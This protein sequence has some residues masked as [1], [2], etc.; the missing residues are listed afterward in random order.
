RRNRNKKKPFSE[1]NR[2]LVIEESALS[3]KDLRSLRQTER[4][5]NREEIF[6]L[7]KSHSNPGA[8]YTCALCD[9]L[10]ESVSD[11]YRHIRD[12]RHKKRARERQEQ[13]MLTEI[14][15][16]G[17]EQISAV[18]AALQAVVQ[19]HGMNDQD[20]E[21]RQCVVSVMQDLLLSIFTS[22]GGF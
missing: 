22:V 16:P 4:R 13:V 8:L 19:Q 20:V 5:L 17:P 15:P 2:G 1:E 12:K 18:S 7:K 6:S 10:L 11:A 3:A 21:K 9:V 14:L